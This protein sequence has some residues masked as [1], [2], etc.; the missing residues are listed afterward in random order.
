MVCDVSTAPLLSRVFS[1][2]VSGG[3]GSEMVSWGSG[4]DSMGT[5]T[6]EGGSSC[7]DGVRSEAVPVMDCSNGDEAVKLV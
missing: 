6:E 1:S 2:G 5:W 4:W 3:V 7:G